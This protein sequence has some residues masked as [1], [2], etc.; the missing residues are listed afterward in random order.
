MVARRFYKLF[1]HIVFRIRTHGRGHLGQGPQIL[2]SNHVGSF[3]PISVMTSVDAEIRPWVAAQVTQIATATERIRR[4][5]VEGE[6]GL[7]PPLSRWV[8]RIVGRICV[9][10]MRDI[11]AIPVYECGRALKR[12]MELTLEEL[13][14][15]RSVLVFPENA[16]R[17]VNEV[18]CDFRTGFIHLAREYHRRTRRPI[19]FL[20]LAVHPQSQVIRIGT[21]IPFDADAPFAGE[22]ARLKRELE[23]RI[24]EMYREIERERS[25]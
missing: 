2:V 3:G 16:E 17:P 19:A 1:R 13:E 8:A 6:L 10:L 5:F 4:E 14:R 21:P 20:P 25:A 23:R 12:T 11:G 24:S 7:R 22:K 15:G 18:L 9:A